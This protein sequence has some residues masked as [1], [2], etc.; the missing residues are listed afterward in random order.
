VGPPM[1]WHRSWW[2]GIVPRLQC[3][4]TGQGAKEG[5]CVVNIVVVVGHL[6]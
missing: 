6:T 1:M 3:L 2:V 4:H 5:G